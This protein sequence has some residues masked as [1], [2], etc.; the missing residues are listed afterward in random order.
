MYTE[1][2]HSTSIWQ[3]VYE[4]IKNVE[5]KGVSLTSKLLWPM[6]RITI[7]LSVPRNAFAMKNIFLRY[8]NVKTTHKNTQL[9]S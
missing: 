7:E 1:D 3:K 4:N 2:K 8:I 5:Q 6:L 9:Y